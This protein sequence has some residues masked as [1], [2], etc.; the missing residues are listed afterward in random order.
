[1]SILWRPPAGIE[2]A[3]YGFEFRTEKCR[4][5]LSFITWECGEKQSWSVKGGNCDCENWLVWGYLKPLRLGSQIFTLGLSFVFML[6]KPVSFDQQNVTVEVEIM[7]HSL[8]NYISEQ[9]T[10]T[11]PLCSELYITIS[12]RIQFVRDAHIHIDRLHW[13]MSLLTFVLYVLH[14][15]SVTKYDNSLS[16]YP[17]WCDLHWLDTWHLTWKWPP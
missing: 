3:P 5:S 1:M 11:F 14:I 10:R 4:T 9:L 7:F 13:L 12:A 2:A 6:K 17:L 16:I 15:W 8:S